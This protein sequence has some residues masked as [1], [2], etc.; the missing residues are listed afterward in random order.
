VANGKARIVE[1]I[2]PERPH[3][4]YARKRSTLGAALLMTAPGIP[5]L[6]QGQEF[7]EDRWF[8][9]T[10]PLD[11]NLREKFP[12]IVTLYRDLIHLRRNH[13]G[14]TP[15]LVGQHARVY[16]HNPVEKVLVLHRWGDADPEDGV[17]AVFNFRNQTLTD[18][19]V[20]LPQGGL[21]RLR[22]DSHARD[23]DPEYAGQV[24]HD[25]TAEEGAADDMPFYSRVSVAPYSAL[26]YSREIPRKD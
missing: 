4:W 17:V 22:F 13:S 7:M 6:F 3:S 26:I 2:W 15:G 9:N 11:W 5:M 14:V 20:G 21:W 16:H 18:Y 12:G 10:D 23:Y 1:E 19:R 24:S 25:M 8:E